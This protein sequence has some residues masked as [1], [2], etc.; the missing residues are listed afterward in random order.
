MKNY[1]W[2]VVADTQSTWTTDAVLTD[3]NDGHSDLWID[4]DETDSVQTIASEFNSYSI[5]QAI[6]KVTDEENNVLW[7]HDSN[8]INFETHDWVRQEGHWY[9]ETTVKQG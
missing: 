9:L 7:T 3:L 1:K 8:L 6:V 2:T 4:Y 5:G